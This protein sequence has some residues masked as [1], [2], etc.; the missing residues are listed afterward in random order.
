MKN[1]FH[2]SEVIDTEVLQNI[3]NYFSNATGLAVVTVDY[4]GVPITEYSNF[5]KFCNL[6]RKDHKCK[7]R[8]FYS[9]AHGGLEA[10]RYRRP[11]IYICHSGLVDFAIP[12][13][14]NEQYLGS[15]MAGQIKINEKIDIEDKRIKDTIETWKK[16]PEI[17]SAYEEVPSISYEKVNAAAHMM[18]IVANHIVEKGLASIY[19]EELNKKNMELLKETKTRSELEKALKNAE[20]KALQSQLNPHFLFNVLNTIGRL[21]LLEGAV[22]TEETVFSFSEML[23]YTLEKSTKIVTLNDALNYIEKY[24]SIQ[25]IRFPDRLSYNIDI[26]DYV[27]DTKIPFMTLQPFVENA[28]NHGIEPKKKGGFINITGK[29]IR[30]DLVIKIEDNGVGMSENEVEMILGGIEYETSSKS[31]GIG[32]KNVNSMLIN[33][34][35][36]EY[37][38]N[39]MSKK[40]KGTTVKIRIPRINNLRGVLNV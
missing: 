37:G 5:S 40:E 34:F 18:H 36:D 26:P 6:I 16:D 25:K 13:V 3:Q 9:D 8:C 31:T 17:L 24:L 30:E 12:I 38:I 32:I 23:R 21:A 4:T 20:L 35:G 29:I 14:V 2:L 7:K 19:Q 1:L 15:I 27:L 33:C 11:H 28:V 22:K 10:V 39:I